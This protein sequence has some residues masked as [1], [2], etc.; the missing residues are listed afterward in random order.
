MFNGHYFAAHYFAPRYFS[1]IGAK[2]VGYLVCASLE[3][4]PRVIGAL[5][6][7]PVAGSVNLAPAVTGAPDLEQC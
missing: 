6:L 2:L 4:A 3:I 5:A 1:K 7:T